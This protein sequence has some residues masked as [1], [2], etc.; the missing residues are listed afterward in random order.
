M[1]IRWFTFVAF[2]LVALSLG[3]ADKPADPPAEPAADAKDAKKDEHAGH[4]AA[5]SGTPDPAAKAGA[6]KVFFKFPQDKSK[7]FGKVAIAFGL[8]G[9]TI[10]PAGQNME[11]KS[12]GHHHVVIDGEP[13][14]A[15]S[16]VP[17]DDKNIHFGKGQT[18]AELTLTPGKHK[19]TMQF[20]DGA[21]LSFGPAMAS[22]IEVE[23]VPDQ[24]ERK[25]KFLAPA[26]GA[27]VKSPFK[28]KFGLEGMKVRPATEDPLDKTTGHH[29]LVIDGKP[30]PLGTPVP[31]DEMHI[32]YGKG[33]TE[34]DLEL[35]LGKHTLTMQ[36]ADGGHL[37]YGPALSATINVEVIK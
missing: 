29:H 8:E 27:K 19:L 3:C 15:G 13:V 21:H 6:S 23:V 2:A 32:H 16:A 25:V 5:G 20:A 17:A 28:V 31:A 10:S 12:M 26:E 30:I 7:V 34:V 14:A 1:P 24:G 4:A 9:K 37:S 18:E 11:D 35:P 22:T 33:Q 36:L